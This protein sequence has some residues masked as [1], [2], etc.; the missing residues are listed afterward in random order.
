MQN[1][2]IKRHLN[3]YLGLAL[4]V[5]LALAA[6]FVPQG[7]FALRDAADVDR[8]HG[9]VLSP[10]MVAQLDSNYERDIHNRLSACLEAIAAQDVM[11]SAKEVD[12]DNEALLENIEQANRSL[13]MELFLSEQFVTTSEKQGWDSAI[14]SCTQYV[15]MRKSDG[16]ILLV[17]NDI[18]MDKGNG[19]HM[20]LLLDGMDG[21]LYYLE[22]EEFITLPD[23]RDWIGGYGLWSWW[24]ILNDTYYTENAQRL[25]S[26][27]LEE[28]SENIVYDAQA[29]Y[30]AGTSINIQR[31]HAGD[32]NG[33]GSVFVSTYK[34]NE[35]GET[36]QADYYTKAEVDA[37]KE[38]GDWIFSEGISP[39]IW[40]FSEMNR[41]TYCFQ[42][43]F[44][45][46]SGSWTME[47][48]EDGEKKQRRMRL[49][50]PGIVQAIPEMAQRISLAEYEQIYQRNE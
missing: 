11:C 36:I 20:E 48:E 27:Y 34:Y 49:G 4:P 31:I 29:S 12:P 10:L 40:T 8:V 37:L 26:Y 21:T 16:Q 42:L 47:V 50:L 30:D 23:I 9:E 5:V 3:R 39:N 33:D 19:W 24:W 1:S 6:L 2:N 38:A 7:W 45:E 22:D 43:A 32:G 15:L 25:N 14:K 46:I 18:Y 13:L 44:G 17:A 41:E 35:Y 28:D